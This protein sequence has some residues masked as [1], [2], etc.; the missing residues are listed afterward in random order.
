MIINEYTSSF[1]C[2]LCQKK[3]SSVY[4]YSTKYKSVVGTSWQLNPSFRSNDFECYCEQCWRDRRM[5]MTNLWDRPSKLFKAIQDEKKNSLKKVFDGSDYSLLYLECDKGNVSQF[6]GPQ[7]RSIISRVPYNGPEFRYVFKF[8]SPTKIAFLKNEYIRKIV[9]R[10]YQPYCSNPNTCRSI[11]GS[12][13]N[14][15][16][17]E[18]DKEI[19]EIV[20]D[21][22]GERLKKDYPFVSLQDDE[23]DYQFVSRKDDLMRFAESLVTL[24]RVDY[25]NDMAF[26]LQVYHRI[27]RDLFGL[28]F[29]TV[30]ASPY[31][32]RIAADKKILST[33][34]D[35]IFAN[36]SLLLS[37]TKQTESQFVLHDIVENL[38]VFG[39]KNYAVINA[40][41]EKIT[42]FVSLDEYSTG[43]LRIPAKADIAKLTRMK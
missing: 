3:A 11:I 16:L 25:L 1:K 27:T 17:K 15:C 39:V 5:P 33:I 22:F 2:D 43:S 19:I 6:D 8:S 42:R 28:G 9:N 35:N 14:E 40:L 29:H 10:E 34:R 37:Y 32:E 30:N 23:N 12:F 36:E 24:N 41:L 31:T 26:I 38:E 4:V 20:S 13:W 18:N 7:L 21:Q